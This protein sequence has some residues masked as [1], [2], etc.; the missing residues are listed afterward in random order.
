MVSLV[1]LACN[2]LWAFQPENDN[3][4]PINAGMAG[5]WANAEIPGQGLFVDVDPAARTVFLAWFTYTNEGSGSETIIGSS[6]NFWYVALGNYDEGNNEVT[7]TLI[8]T[9]PGVF[10]QADPVEENE[11]GELTLTFQ[12][13][14]AASMEFSFDDGTQGQVDLVRLTAADV[15]QSLAGN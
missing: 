2:A 15:C 14:E 13:C 5:S 10:D 8:E 12:N 11:V 4:L 3:G 7:L 1:G 9:S 6:D